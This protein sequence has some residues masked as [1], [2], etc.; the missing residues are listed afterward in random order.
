VIIDGGTED[1]VVSKETISKLGLKTEKHPS[2]YKIRWVKQGT[3]TLVSK[4]CHF[5]FLIG[6]HYSD[7]IMCIVVDMEAC[8]LILGRP[9]QFDVNA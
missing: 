2:C 6:K 9:W 3:A 8:H 5:T 4:R 7:S 1:N